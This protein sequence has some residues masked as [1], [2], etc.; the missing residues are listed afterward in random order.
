MCGMS[1]RVVP[2]L[3]EVVA[4]EY[5]ECFELKCDG[6]ELEW[7]ETLVNC[8][9][10]R[11]AP[12]PELDRLFAS[13]NEPYAT[14]IRVAVRCGDNQRDFKPK[15]L[16]HTVIERLKRWALKTNAHLQPGHVQFV[17]FSVAAEQKNASFVNLIVETYRLKELGDTLL[18]HVR[19]LITAH[20]YKTA[21]HFAVALDLDSHFTLE[22]LIVP[23]FLQDKIALVEE[24]LDKR[25]GRAVDFIKYLD[26]LVKHKNVVQQIHLFLATTQVPD[27]KWDKMYLKPIGKLIVRLCKKYSVATDTCENLAHMRAYRGVRFLVRQK[28]DNDSPLSN[29]AWSDLIED[30]LATTPLLLKEVVSMVAIH[31]PNEALNLAK[32]YRL[33]ECNYP[34]ELIA[35]L[36]NDK[37]N[38]IHLDNVTHSDRAHSND[39]NLILD[40][41]T[42]RIPIQDVIIVNERN[43]FDF[44]LH[45][46]S[47]ISHYYRI[48]QLHFKLFIGL[49]FRFTHC[50]TGLRVETVIWNQTEFCL[51]NSN[52]FHK[53]SLHIRRAR[54]ERTS[55]VQFM[56]PTLRCHF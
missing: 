36:A 16:P 30:A 12:L 14:A 4:R 53:Q 55:P 3:E 50:W 47:G 26:E 44:A 24:L 51:A 48:V 19:S 17:A 33:P 20:N 13:S 8:W 34:D 15:T 5:G 39:T 10:V 42:L 32:K 56:A 52:G 11:R 49:I 37:L 22:E 41:Y 6:D 35:N 9:R 40:Y 45:H 29:E 2:S 21:S 27:I 25:P 18:P 28:Y 38:N 23:L 46:L 54:S 43:T 31:D 1:V 7:A